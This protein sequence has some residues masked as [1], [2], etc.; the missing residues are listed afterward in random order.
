M[1]IGRENEL[2]ELQ[3][4]YDS[5][6]FQC[7]VI[8]GRR[9][10][11][12][13][14]L[15]SRFIA[16]KPAIFFTAQEANDTINLTM[17]SEKVLDFFNMSGSGIAFRDWNA[18]FSFL[19]QKAQNER[20]VLA[21]DEF[22]YACNANKGLRSVLQNAIDHQF[23]NGK[24]FLILCGSHVS[25]MERE[26]LGTKSPLFGRRTMQLR[27]T[28][29]DYYDS[30]LMLNEFS[31]ED[32][33]GFFACIGGTPHY[34]AQI[35]PKL[36]FADNIKRL[37]FRS[38]GYLYSEP[39]MLLQQE[40]REPATYNSII[41][42]IASGATR[43]NDIVLKTGEERMKI[44][45]YIRVL[46]D[47]KIIDRTLPFGEEPGKSRK[48]VYRITDNCYRFWYRFVFGNQAEIDS[49]IGAA[50]ADK[51]VF[52]EALASFIGKPAFE[53]ICLQYLMRLNKEQKLP[54]L[55]TSFGKWWGT[56]NQKREETDIDIVVGDKTGKKA[57]L[58]ECKWRKEKVSKADIEN[59]MK[60][61]YLLPNFTNRY[62]LFFSKSG[63]NQGAK[64]LAKNYDRLLLLE[65]KDLFDISNPF[66]KIT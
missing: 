36:S 14:Y 15:I 61:D 66:E 65:L 37:Y 27:L 38:S 1:F 21:F 30:A 51:T 57:I 18:V 32:K 52:G 35:N 25:F 20:L 58:G 60:K 28:G 2:R 43:L 53:Q 24:L 42:S 6:T 64:E 59:F 26:V 56:D 3:E 49:G 4:A 46:I 22:P 31:Y 40:M 9:R 44:S 41:A 5:D 34:L 16:D 48:G 7:A 11:G 47:M 17:F 62:Y 23:R 39:F 10:I 12:K 29:F 45:K 33:V 19:A 13:T 8:Y 50:L 54:F 63:Y 55:A